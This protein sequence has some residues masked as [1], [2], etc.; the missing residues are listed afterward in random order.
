VSDFGMKDRHAITAQIIVVAGAYRPQFYHEKMWLY[1]IG[2]AAQALWHGQHAGNHFSIFVQ[3]QGLPPLP[4]SEFVNLFGPQRFGDGFV[5]VGRLLIEGQMAA[6]A[7]ILLAS[8]KNS[9]KLQ[10][11]MGQY[12]LP[13]IAAIFHSDFSYELKMKIHGWQSHLWNERAADWDGDF[14]PLWRPKHASLYRR[15]WNPDIARLDTG[16]VQQLNTAHRPVMATARR[17]TVTHE[18]QGYRHEFVLP[19]GSYATVFLSQLY[20]LSDASREQ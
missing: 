16:M 5:E 3:S 8:P 9:Q 10:K 17:H 18:P 20:E 12:R 19:S 7:D 4:R 2:P 14:L 11:I 13:A 1:Q 15:L 6:A